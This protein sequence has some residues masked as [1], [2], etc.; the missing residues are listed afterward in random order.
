MPPLDMPLFFA[1]LR[2]VIGRGSKASTSKPAKRWWGHS[3]LVTSH[4]QSLPLFSKQKKES[5][6]FFCATEKVLTA[7]LLFTGY[8][9]SK[10]CRTVT[11]LAWPAK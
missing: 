3:V 11:K 1:L 5:A 7:Y 4:C 10:I 8:Y 6:H 9:H 2:K